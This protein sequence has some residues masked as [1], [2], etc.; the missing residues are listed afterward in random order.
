M[1]GWLFWRRSHIHLRVPWCRSLCLPE[2]CLTDILHMSNLLFLIMRN[3]Y[4][5]QGFSPGLVSFFP[6]LVYY[7]CLCGSHGNNTWRS[8]SKSTTACS[9]MICSCVLHRLLYWSPHCTLIRQ[10]KKCWCVK[11]SRPTKPTLHVVS[12][13]FTQ[14]ALLLKSQS[15]WPC[16]SPWTCTR[17][18]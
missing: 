5:C 1:W 10:R 13:I 3:K 11:A 12:L 8:R 16:S 7:E 4:N 18:F 2:T 9:G 6:S 15:F 17:S 14:R